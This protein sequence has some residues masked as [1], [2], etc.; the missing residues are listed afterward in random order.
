[1]RER[2]RESKA[3]IYV[4][5]CR[6]DGLLRWR[7]DPP[8][9]KDW[10]QKE[11]ESLLGNATDMVWLS[12]P[13]STSLSSPQAL[14]LRSQDVN[15]VDLSRWWWRICLGSTLPFIRWSCRV[16]LVGF[17]LV[18]WRSRVEWWITG[19]ECRILHQNLRS[20]SPRSN[21]TQDTLDEMYSTWS[22]LRTLS[23]SLGIHR[24]ER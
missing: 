2:E 6:I 17:G 23:L 5:Y 3:R 13:P 9:S 15:G 10:F 4:L 21:Q 16:G 19:V 14:G 22:T 11:R 1:M 20:L 24:W 8:R 7:S 12:Y 18:W